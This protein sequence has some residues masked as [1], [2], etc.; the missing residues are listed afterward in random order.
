MLVSEILRIKG[1]TLF[2]ATPDMTVAEAVL[3]ATVG[4]ATA[5]RRQDVGRLRIGGRADMVMLDAPS[6]IHLAYRPGV[7]LVAGVWRA[8]R[9]VIGRVR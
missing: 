3:A 5:L 6:H 2:T 1:S 8:G 9:R 4:G 7:N